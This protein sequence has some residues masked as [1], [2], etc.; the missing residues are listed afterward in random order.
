MIN[1]VE[2][3]EEAKKMMSGNIW[4]LLM[5]WL[6]VL[7]VSFVISL[8]GNLFG[9]TT[10]DYQTVSFS[11]G[12]TWLTLIWSLLTGIVTACV[13]VGV[14]NYYLMFVRGKNPTINDVFTVLKDKTVLVILVSLL[15][16]VLI[17]VGFILFVIPGVILS[18]GYA[19]VNYIICD[20]EKNSVGAWEVLKKSWNMMNGYKMDYFVLVLSFFG[21]ILLCFLIIPL[22]Y[23]V[24]YMEVTVTLYYE[25]LKSL[26]TTVK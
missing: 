16:T 7:G 25:K 19:M 24:P 13:T 9:F 12:K 11:D 26:K 1:R 5:P 22:I 18:F 14:T 10:I 3:K 17:S 15:S 20:E 8:L 4:N 21:W 23:V 2:L 6:I